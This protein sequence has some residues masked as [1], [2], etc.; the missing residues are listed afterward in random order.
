MHYM[1]VTSITVPLHPGC[2][3]CNYML[4]IWN[5]DHM[6]RIWQSGIYTS[7]PC[8]YMFIPVHRYVNMYIPCIHIY[9]Q[10]CKCTDVSI[11][12][13]KAICAILCVLSSCSVFYSCITMG[14]Y[15]LRRFNLFDLP[16]VMRA[17]GHS[18]LCT[19]G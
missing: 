12:F 5:P 14:P 15:V 4:I 17:L 18:T 16:H 13:C 3:S 2:N 9:I 6:D 11:H 10:I 19:R 7:I 1:V 8:I